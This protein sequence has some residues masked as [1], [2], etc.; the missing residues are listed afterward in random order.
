M[1]LLLSQSLA[2]FEFL[3]QVTAFLI[4]K[5]QLLRQLINLFGLRNLLLLG[6]EERLLELIQLIQKGLVVLLYSL[7]DFELSLHQS[8]LFLQLNNSLSCFLHHLVLI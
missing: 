4:C 5:L 7:L 2:F 1:R 3:Q 8:Q 6:F